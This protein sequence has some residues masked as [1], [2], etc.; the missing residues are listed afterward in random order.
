MNLWIGLSALQ[1]SQF[2]I[3]SVSHN[4]ANA[5]TEGY[6]RQEVGLETRQ[7]QL[8]GGRFIGSGVEVGYVRRMRDQIVES[9]FT[10]SLTDLSAID[11][12]LQIESRIES[13]LLPGEG[14]VQSSLTGMFDEFV[15]LSAN[16]N[17]NTLR[18]SV[19]SEGVN[20]ASRL[21]QLSSDFVELKDSIGRQLELEVR[22]L[23]QDI[24]TL[25][26]L[27][28]RINSIR[29]HDVPNDLLDQRDQL[30]NS[31]AERIDIQRYELVQNELGLGIAGSS[32][33]IGVAPIQFE[34][35][36]GEDGKLSVRVQGSDRETNFVSGKVAALTGLHND[37]VDHFMSKI[38]EFASALIRQVDQAHAVGV[39]LNGPYSI[40]HGTRAAAD[41][42]A[43]LNNSGL[44]FPVEAGDLYLTVTASDGS[45]R[46][47]SISIDPATDSLEDIAVKISS[48]DNIQ[49]IVDEQT[50]KLS[51]IAARGYR[52]DFTGNLETTP[53]LT[54]F[55]GTSVPS[56][57][58]SYTGDT[59]GK[60]TIRIDGS[61]AIGQAN[62]LIAQVVNEGGQV[63]KEVNIGIGYE[64]G[65]EL[66]VGNGVTIG[67]PAGDVVAGDSFEVIT[68][69]NADT[70]GILSA[71]GLN[72]FFQGTNASDIDVDSRIISDSDEIATSRSGDIGDTRN[73]AAL[74][75]LRDAPVLAD[76]RLTFDDFL[77]ETNTEIG[78]HVQSS[79]NVR[80][81]VAELNF[82][83]QTER[84][85]KS[86]VD[87]NEELL[88]MTQYQKSYEAAVQVL[89]TMDS[90]LS[91]LFQIIR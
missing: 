69:A 53:D 89:R 23:N 64:P 5:S 74:I 1:A 48:V 33:S 77:A 56:I 16:P 29:I 91:E 6:H 41:I 79:K 70:S 22:G 25:V 38:D 82:Q 49:A 37:F 34:T 90:M 73:L 9:A 10:N 31:I 63:I 57:G 12:R 32:I 8:I 21:R 36:T 28:N 15:R 47:T 54:N 80:A 65:S 51:V 50:G 85:S 35:V 84:D 39:G 87:I 17:E 62:N 45:R 30:I 3:N 72:S 14:S 60:F 2:G 86:G 13:F 42:S 81:N 75:G 58:G 83:Y 46:I 7:S 66:D 76:N 26:E 19:V 71:L 40:L 88:F 59:N 78:F 44:A 11:Q 52:F 18:N 67:F 27:Q 24:E 43:S 55:S 68:V 61:G 20:L 4:L